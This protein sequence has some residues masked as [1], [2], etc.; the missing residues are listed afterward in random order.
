MKKSVLF[1]VLLVVGFLGAVAAE[2]KFSLR[3]LH[4]AGAEYDGKSVTHIGGFRGSVNRCSGFPP[5]SKS[6]WV[7]VDQTGCV[8][9][10]GPMPAGIDPKKAKGEPVRV[11]GTVRI[12]KNGR[13]YIEAKE[14][15]LLTPPPQK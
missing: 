15:V 11:T 12:A 7:M 4:S 9:V 1:L 3:K 8:W 14:T 5:V 13:P 6:D 2:E 10:S